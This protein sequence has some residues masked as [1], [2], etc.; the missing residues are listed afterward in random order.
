MVHLT[1]KIR[2]CKHKHASTNTDTRRQRSTHLFLECAAEMLPSPANRVTRGLDDT[3]W[4]EENG[5]EV[6]ERV[7]MHAKESYVRHSGVCVC[8][9]ESS[10]RDI[11]CVCVRPPTCI[12]ME[13]VASRDAD[14]TERDNEAQ[15]RGR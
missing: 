5:R 2:T 14:E 8:D 3:L 4:E 13:I 15:H 6:C 9:R 11:M 12:Q 1:Q 10:E 7:S